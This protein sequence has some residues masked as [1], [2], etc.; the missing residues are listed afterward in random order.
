MY[1][2]VSA[3]FDDIGCTWNAGPVICLV[4]QTVDVWK[5]HKIVMKSEIGSNM[6]YKMPIKIVRIFDHEK[7]WIEKIA[8]LLSHSI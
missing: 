1:E 8:K 3:N 4:W 2:S 6:T 5:V 7:M